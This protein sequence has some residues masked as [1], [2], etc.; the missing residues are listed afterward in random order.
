MRKSL[1]RALEPVI[2]ATN[3]APG[4]NHFDTFGWVYYRMGDLGNARRSFG[5]SLEME[6]ENAEATLHRAIVS[7]GSGDKTR[8]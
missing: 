7:V 5:R 2:V 1:E 6:P 4:A 3:A 8:A